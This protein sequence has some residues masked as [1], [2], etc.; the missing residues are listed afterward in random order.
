MKLVNLSEE[1]DMG[2]AVIFMFSI[3]ISTSMAFGQ[4]FQ[5]NWRLVRDEESVK[6][7]LHRS[8][9]NV[10]GSVQINRRKE[11]I[12][13]NKVTREDFFK[14]LE[15]KKK[16]LLS[17]IGVT[18]WIASDYTWTNRRSINELTVVGTYKDSSGQVVQFRELHLFKERRTV[19]ILYTQSIGAKVTAKTA[20][21]FVASVRKSIG[22]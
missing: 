7:Y 4:S 9:T 10:A 6:T 3:C 18:D 15:E 19:Q 1:I 21:D 5:E 17:L 12:D 13:W 11:P 2:N 14:S 16:Q 20:D 8:D 22:E